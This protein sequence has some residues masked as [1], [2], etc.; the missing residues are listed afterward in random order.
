MAKCISKTYTKPVVTTSFV[1]TTE[2]TLTLN[3]EEAEILRYI[4]GCIGGISDASPRGVVDQIINELDFAGI[5]FN[6]YPV[7]S[8]RCSIYFKTTK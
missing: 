4:C 5:P 6:E 1:E 2:Y 3:K 7:E 8:D